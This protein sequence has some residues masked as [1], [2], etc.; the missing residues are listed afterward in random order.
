MGALLIAAALSG[1]VAVAMEAYA[2][3]GL[4]AGSQMRDWVETAARYQMW[5]ALALLGVVALAAREGR[6]ALL[7]RLAAASFLAGMLLFCG[8]LYVLALAGWRSVAAAAPAGG[9]ALILGWIAL[10]GYGVER[11]RGRRRN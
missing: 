5:H 6:E 8:S 2:A 1:A 11:W 3:H 7:L 10:A 9:A 4:P